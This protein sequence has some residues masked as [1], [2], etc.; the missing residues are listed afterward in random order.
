MEQKVFNISLIILIKKNNR[1]IKSLPN[2]KA[3]RPNNIPNE[4]FKIVVLIITKD[5]AKAA[6]YCFINKTIL[7]SLK[8]NL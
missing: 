4:V 1:L 3:L 6:N 2:R 5:L 8:N 7:K